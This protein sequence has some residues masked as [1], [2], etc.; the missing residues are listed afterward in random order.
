M[1]KKTLVW[2]ATVIVLS[3]IV[4]CS[5]KKG[6]ESQTTAVSDPEESAGRE[7]AGPEDGS[8]ASAPEHSAS[9]PAD[10]DWQDAFQFVRDAIRTE[11]SRYALKTAA[12]VEW[13]RSAN[14]LEKALFLAG[15]LRENGK[16]VEVARGTLDEAAAKALLGAIFPP[17]KAAS[18]KSGVPISNPAEDPALVAAVARHHWV[19]MQDGD[20]WIDLDPSFPAAEPGRAFAALEESLDPTDEA[21][22]ARV[23]ISVDYEEGASGEPQSVLAW[24]GPIGDVANK[25]LSLAVMTEYRGA[26]GGEEEEEEGGAGGLFGGLG[27]GTSG[28]KKASGDAQ[29]FLKTSLT[30]GEERLAEGDVALGKEP[31][32]RLTLQV[33]VESQGQVVSDSGRVLF[34]TTTGKPGAPLFQRHAILI[35]ADRLPAAAWKD[36]LQ[37][38]S[39][40]GARTEAKARVEEIRA[41]LKSK[42]ATGKTLSSGVEL[43]EKLGR[44]VGHLMNMIFA[45]T[46]D[47]QTEK[48]GAALSVASWYAVP[49][50]IMTSVGGSEKATETA[51]DLRQDRV[52]SVSLPGQAWGMS[53][54]FQYGRGVMESIL[55]G[56]LLAILSGKPA[57]TTAFI[58]EEA[59]RK[60]VAVRMFSALEKDTLKTLG[61]PK[62]VLDRIGAALENGRIVMVPEKGILWEGRERWGWWE[63]DPRTRETIGVLDTGLHQ[64]MI[65]QTI[66]QAEGPMQSRMGAVL[67]AMVGAIDTYWLLMGM[68]LKHGELNK[69]ALLEAKAYM[70]DIQSVMCPGFEK[71]VSIEA[72]VTVVEIEDCYKYELEIFK[73][74]AGIEIKQGWCEQFAKGFA[75]ASTSILNYLISQAGD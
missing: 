48:A 44:D 2:V 67:G 8:R 6:E 68:V 9:L 51:I 66:L 26:E 12:G 4:S 10:G 46:S 27:G 22:A 62:D 70:K 21:L 73:A 5:G 16:T 29:A 42:K 47:D 15:L 71:K 41:S 56:K 37:S 7:Q 63:V 34:E 75:C 45:S 55:E 60:N 61:P 69:A 24:E 20:D 49:R 18:Y 33:K 39:D 57:L 11:P 13:G 64:A 58:M 19:R 3:G 74:E 38:V 40:S 1:S 31:A 23:S 52:E 53:Q 50:I 32:T 30:A 17:A 14:P 28:K 36:E 43:E 65:D 54:A 59:A 35:T 25:P 72:S